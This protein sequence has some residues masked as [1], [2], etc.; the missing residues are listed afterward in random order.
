MAVPS[1]RVAIADRSLARGAGARRGGARGAPG[2]SSDDSGIC[3][4]QACSGRE[5]RLVPT[6]FRRRVSTER[7][8]RDDLPRGGLRWR[9]M[10]AR[11]QGDGSC[12][13]G[14]GRSL[15][16]GACAVWGWRALLGLLRGAGRR[17]E[18]EVAGF[19]SAHAG[20]EPRAQAA[21]FF[22]RSALPQPGCDAGWRLRI[23]SACQGGHPPTLPGLVP[24]H[25]A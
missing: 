20:D 3:R 7:A 8:Q 9:C 24:F 13:Q 2:Y 12:R 16:P 10:D 25:S 18:S 22:L 5:D 21:P 1:G 19:P 11:C 4:K 14:V 15:R 6:A 23:R 17:V